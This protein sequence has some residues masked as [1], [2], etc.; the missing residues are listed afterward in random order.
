M[1]DAN[2]DDQT[3][4]TG[5]QTQ[6]VACVLKESG[7]IAA[8]KLYMEFTGSSLLN[9]K[10]AVESL[11]DP[12][13]PTSSQPPALSRDSDL[14]NDSMDAILDAIGRGQKLQAVKLYMQS[15]DASL[16]QSKVFIEKLQ[17]ELGIEDSKGGGCLGVLLLIV[18]GVAVAIGY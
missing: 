16:M 5:E 11:I 6:Q 7:K 1:N 2:S 15:S 4:L 3:P 12:A 14:D 13:T 18:A 17:E 8:V 10:H 9:A